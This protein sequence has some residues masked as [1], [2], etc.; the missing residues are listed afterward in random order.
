MYLKKLYHFFQHRQQFIDPGCSGHE[1]AP[2]TVANTP[3]FTVLATKI[4]KLVA[5]LVYCEIK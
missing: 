4:Q 3:K 1:I 2:D 5:T